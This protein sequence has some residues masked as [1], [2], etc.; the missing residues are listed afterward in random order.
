MDNFVCD[1]LFFHN[2]IG[3]LHFL[4][5]WKEI[6]YYMHIYGQGIEENHSEIDI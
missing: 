5:S 4:I 1:L 2:I 3:K 6:G